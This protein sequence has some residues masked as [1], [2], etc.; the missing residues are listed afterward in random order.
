MY[1][2]GQVLRGLRNPDLIRKELNK[3][4][5]SRGNTRPYN[6]GGIDVFEED[7]DTLVVLDA[8]RYD[9]FEQRHALPGRLDRR[10][11]RASDTEEFLRANFGGRALHDVVYV[12]GNPQLF[13]KD[14]DTSL[15][16]VKNVWR[17]DGWDDR[18]RTVLPE[19]M[20]EWTL[21]AAREFPYKRLVVH[22][23]QPHYPFIGGTGRE[24]FENGSL[25]F[26]NRVESGEI[27]ASDHVLELAYRE[28][29]DIVL[30]HVEELLAELDG[31]TVV[32]ADHGQM[33]G[34]RA[35]VLPRRYYGHPGGVYHENLVAVPWLVHETGSRRET[36]PEPPV[37]SA[38]G[39]G[40]ERTAE[41]RLRD[42]GYVG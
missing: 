12:T 18:Y 16:A 11:S 38:P 7:W 3:L 15:H 23:M 30:P 32:T 26:W 25:A 5:Y 9:I 6:V 42:L 2:P 22:Y 33:L 41:R 14:I 4:Y 24:H 37:T 20:T 29:L 13:R 28:N 10:E 17:E 40:D 39:P 19:K 1:S 34:E 35:G 31:K 27:D 8:C 21:E 36:Y